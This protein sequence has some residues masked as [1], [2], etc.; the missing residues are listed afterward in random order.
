MRYQG[1]E[2]RLKERSVGGTHHGAVPHRSLGTQRGARG[3]KYVAISVEMHDRSGAWRDQA[4]PPIVEARGIVRRI[5]AGEVAVAAVAKRR[6][7]GMFAAAE[8]DLLVALGLE[9]DGRET[10][11][12]VR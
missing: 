7:A 6:A 10:R 5:A 2:L 11:P 9:G 8:D 12:R 3:R 1:V 4:Y